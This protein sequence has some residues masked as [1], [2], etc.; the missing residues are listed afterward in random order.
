MIRRAAQTVRSP[1][2]RSAPMARVWALIQVRSENSGAK[3]ARVATISGGR[4]TGVV[5][6]ND[7]SSTTVDR[8]QRPPGPASQHGQS[9]VPGKP[10]IIGGDVPGGLLITLG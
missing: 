8:G 7:G 10:G 6:T 4:S 5:S 1:A 2:A 9:R 3:A